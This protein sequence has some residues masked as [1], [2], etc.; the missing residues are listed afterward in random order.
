MQRFGV[1]LENVIHVAPGIIASKRCN[2]VKI[3][4]NEVYDG[5]AQ[6]AGIFLHRSTDSCEV[7]GK[8]HWI[9]YAS[10]YASH[11]LGEHIIW[12]PRHLTCLVLYPTTRMVP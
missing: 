1:L 6:A 12:I 8:H 7:Y 10:H 2:H 11:G 4:D 9:A 5:G 3:F